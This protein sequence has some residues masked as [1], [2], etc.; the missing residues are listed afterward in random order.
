MIEKRMMMKFLTFCVDFEKHEEDYKGNNCIENK[1]CSHILHLHLSGG[2]EEFS[3]TAMHWY[4]VMNFVEFMEKLYKEYLEHQKLSKNVIHFIQ[5]A[6]SMT[7]DSTPTPEVNLIIKNM[8]NTSSISYIKEIIKES[9]YHC[10]KLLNKLSLIL[11]L[12]C[13]EI[14]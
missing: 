13:F 7:S 1:Y 14:I 4:F 5:H 12:N 10:R 11:E 2:N 6:I 8:K 9:I 3:D